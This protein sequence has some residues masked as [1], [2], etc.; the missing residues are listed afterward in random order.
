[1][2]SSSAH[3]QGVNTTSRSI[4]I[5]ESDKDLDFGSFFLG[6]AARGKRFRPNSRGGDYVGPHVGWF[7]SWLSQP[8][9]VGW[10]ELW[11]DVCVCGAGRVGGA[12]HDA[13]SYVAGVSR[14]ARA[15][16]RHLSE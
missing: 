3:A 13:G 2:A 16:F 1:M 15:V 10:W 4:S 11:Y 5:L 6:L 8:G 7:R 14:C 9:W 12:A